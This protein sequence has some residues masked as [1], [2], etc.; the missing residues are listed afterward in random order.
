[1]VSYRFTNLAEDFPQRDILRHRVAQR[2]F[3]VDAGEL[4]GRR[5]EVGAL[6]GVDIPTDGAIDS[7]KP[8]LRQFEKGCRH[9]EDAIGIGIETAGF[10]V[11]DDWQ[12]TP[13]SIL[14]CIVPSVT[15]ERAA[16]RQRI[17]SPALNGTTT[18]SPKVSSL[19]TDVSSRTS[20]IEP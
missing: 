7:Q 18:L 13:K 16:T 19:G 8:S 17:L 9:F 6:E 15:H 10:Y 1:M 12:E 14:E 2:A 5:V 3:G 4:E 11:D 20:V